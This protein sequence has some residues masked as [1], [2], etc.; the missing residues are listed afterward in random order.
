MRF[1]LV[2]ISLILTAVP[3]VKAQ[4]FYYQ[5]SCTITDRYGIPLRSILSQDGRILQPVAL[6]D[7]SPWMILAVMAAED[8]RFF[9]HNGVD[10]KAIA[11][12]LWQNISSGEV[13]S[14]A[15]TITQQLVRASNPRGKTVTAKI[16]EAFKAISLEDD[17]SKE[18]IMEAYLNT[19]NFGGNIH[20]V[21]AA[22]QIYF[23][24]SAGALSTAQAAYL[25][26]II[27][28]PYN[29]NPYK[30]PAAALKRKDAVL[31]AMHK[32][33]YID[34]DLH[35]IA[36]AEPI[37]VYPFKNPFRAPHYSEFITKKIDGCKGQIKTTIDG[38]LQDFIEKL[39]PNYLANLK[40][41]K[42][43][44]AAVV[45]LDNRTG[46]I[47]A[48]AGSAD[49]FDAQ[50][51]GYINGALALR[52]PGSSLKPFVYALS[53]E[54]GFLP[55][56]KINDEDKFFGGFRPRNYDE[57]FHGIVSIREALACSYNI[58][59]VTVASE[60]GTSKIL[61][62]LKQLGFKSL[63]ASAEDY[64]LGISLGNGEVK[65]LELA[66]AYRTLANGGV[67][68]PVKYALNPEVA[69]SERAR[70]VFTPQAAYMVT[71]ILSDNN[72]RA[73]AFGL[74]SPLN[75]P[76]PFAAKT[77]T[78][79]DYRD[80]IA[81]GYMKDYT[82]AVWTGNFD[83]K[84][85][86]RVSGITGAAPLLKEIAVFL[87]DNYAGG[88]S[89]AFARPEGMVYLDICP[90]SG[91]PPG[92][93]C[94]KRIREIFPKGKE[95]AGKCALSAQEHKGE[96]LDLNAGI[97]YPQDGDVFRIDPSV[98]PGAQ[99]LVLRARGVKD[100][101]WFINGAPVACGQKCAWQLKKGD[102][103]LELKAGSFTDSI[104]FKVF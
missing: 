81:A 40:A 90:V 87:N 54:N 21:Q 70:Q 12:A 41:N 66:N 78:S 27:K 51:N 80:N 89:G 86:Q 68:R 74:N 37:T 84:P 93:H 5:N 94:T 60:L 61:A 95:P 29:Y 53:F 45:V 34:A 71:D 101:K 57:S 104:S 64:G 2:L 13:V 103:K 72:A 8:K 85:M 100:E 39:L 49:Y 96:K 99:K 75:L 23:N 63:T 9:D 97:V 82:I 76:F 26:G 20:G 79:K 1:L 48:L 91:L 42:V 67:W 10:A 16:K 77:G 58:P 31:D 22:A 15:S 83:G 59:V 102:Y 92:R 46:E 88:K 28:S 4:Q 98:A 65:L 36:L 14:G 43:T 62:K 38:N 55:S 3:C 35:Q 25:A 24:T 6:G 33:G 69:D 7:I 47:L 32:N 19:V 11:R 73:A 17:L 50:N 56:Y 30:K 52:Q 44:N 18:E